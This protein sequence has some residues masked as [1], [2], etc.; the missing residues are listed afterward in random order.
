MAKYLKIQQ[1][2]T[3]ALTG[4][5]V[6]SAFNFLIFKILQPVLDIINQVEAQLRKHKTDLDNDA[7]EMINISDVR[8]TEPGKKPS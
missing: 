8:K 5:E 2:E 3:S 6:A 1:F 4:H 7:S